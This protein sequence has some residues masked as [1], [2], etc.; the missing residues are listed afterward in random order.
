MPAPGRCRSPVRA[1]LVYEAQEFRACLQRCRD[2]GHVIERVDR[3]AHD[4]ARLRNR[5]GNLFISSFAG[6][7]PEIAGVDSS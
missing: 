6:K 5:T 2:L 3:D 1:G 7:K 4:Q